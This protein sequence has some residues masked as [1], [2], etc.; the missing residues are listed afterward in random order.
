MPSD[1]NETWGSYVQGANIAAD[2][3]D[4][5]FT[6]KANDGT[7]QSRSFTG[8]TVLQAVNQAIAIK[9]EIRQELALSIIRL[10]FRLVSGIDS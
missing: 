7:P 5:S 10:C 9:P 3:A 4:F 6:W 8:L 1:I 2:K